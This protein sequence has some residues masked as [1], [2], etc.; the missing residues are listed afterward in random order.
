MGKIKI[1]CLEMAVIA[2]IIS[3]VTGFILGWLWRDKNIDYDID[4]SF[5]DEL[6]EL[7][8]L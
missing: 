4:S 3:S 6:V 7:E 1:N 8:E 2:A 5:G